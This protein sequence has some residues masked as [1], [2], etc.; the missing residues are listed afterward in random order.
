MKKQIIKYLA[1]ILTLAVFT[2]NSLR[3]DPSLQMRQPKFDSEGRFWLYRNGAMHPKM[4]FSPYGW[5][6][7]G[8]NLSQII[9]M[10]LE[11]RDNPYTVIAPPQ[12]ERERC[13]RLKITWGEASWASVAFISGPDSPPWWGDSNIGRYYDLSTLPKKKLVFYARGEK[14]GEV[15]KAQIGALGDKAFGDSLSS[16]INSDELTLTPNWTRY[17]IDLNSVPS[18]GLTNICNG[19]GV[20]VERSSQ[21]QTPDETQI[22]LDDIFYQ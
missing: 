22:F 19:F 2:E 13:I 14:G 11:C 16:P 8:T 17:E 10:D 5:M 15:I 21:S 6:S 7:D 12:P 3:G 18:S 20:V 9:Q 1:I 4:P